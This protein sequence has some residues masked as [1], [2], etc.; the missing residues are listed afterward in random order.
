MAE[1][2]ES[3]RAGAAARVLGDLLTAHHKEGS[4]WA[5]LIEVKVETALLG[6]ELPPPLPG[7]GNYVVAVICAI[8][9]GLLILAAVVLLFMWFIKKHGFRPDGTGL[10]GRRCVSDTAV[11]EKS[12]NLQNEENLRRQLSQMKTLNVME[13]TRCSDH[14]PSMQVHPGDGCSGKLSEPQ[15]MCDSASDSSSSGL[16]RRPEEC[17]YASGECSK[18]LESNPIYKAPMDVRNNMISCNVAAKEVN[19]KVLQPTMQRSSQRM[20]HHLNSDVTKCK[21]VV[22]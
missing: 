6:E 7:R 16:L 3:S 9:A 19:V 12:N 22:V 2:A 10:N 17:S 14:H 13:L 5:T 1:S 21:E 18:A 15:E 11:L 8:A 4:S 20:S